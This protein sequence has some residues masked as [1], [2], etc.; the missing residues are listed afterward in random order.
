MG[1]V[2]AAAGIDHAAVTMWKP[3]TLAQPHAD[4]LELRTGDKVRSTV[5]LPGTEVGTVGKV[6]LANGFNWLRYRVLF[7]NGQ[8][9][10]DL[11]G[12]QIEPYG[13]TVK[14]LEK[15]AEKR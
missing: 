2:H 15:A 11:D 10:G 6:I 12:R 14:R 7:T 13:R 4:Q 1:H 5:E 3:H 8:E 9:I